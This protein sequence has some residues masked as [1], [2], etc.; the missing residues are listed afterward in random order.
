M[1]KRTDY[2]FWGVAAVLLLLLLQGC[3]ARVKL[4][5]LRRQAPSARL[6][7]SDR[8]PRQS[9]DTVRQ[10]KDT[11][12]IRNIEGRD[13]V[14]MRAIRDDD[15]QM[16]A[17]QVLEAARVTARFRNVAERHGRVDIAFQII[18]PEYLQES[19]WQLRYTPTM[20]IMG[21]SVRLDKVIVTGGAYRRR[22]LRGYQQ[23]RRFLDRIASDSSRMINEG[24]LEVFLRRNIPQ[25]YAFKSDTSYVSD[26]EFNSYF[27]VNEQ[28][29]VWHYTNKVLLRLNEY[30]VHSKSQRFKRYV[31][32]PIVT[33][34]IRLDT[35]IISPSGDYIYNYVHSIQTRPYLK[36]VDIVLDGQI[37]EQ[38]RLLCDIARSDMLNFYISSVSAF[39]DDSERY[40]TKIIERRVESS[41]SYLVEF[42]SGSSEVVESLGDNAA[43]LEEIRHNLRGLM[44][45]EIF[46]VDSITVIASASPEGGSAMNAALSQ[47]R[48]ESMT[49]YFDSFVRRQRDSLRRQRGV[50]IAVDDH[51]RTLSVKEADDEPI[52]FL[53][54]SAGEDWA[55]LGRLVEW[56]NT[57]TRSDKDEYASLVASMANADRRE[58]AMK[59]RGWYKYM[60]ENLYPQLRAVHFN[61][62][63]HRRGL[64]KD[65]V[66][67]TVLDTVYMAGVQAIKDRDYDRAIELLR[68]YGDYNTAVAYCAKDYNYSALSILQECPHT[69]Q[70][71]YMLALLHARLGDSQAAVDCYV[72]SCRQDGKYVHR[73]NLDP[74]ISALIRE[75]SLGEVLD[76]LLSEDETFLAD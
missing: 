60:Y 33:S 36:K 75:Y 61:F 1:K 10:H 52:R 56:D 67:T 14:V 7:L 44:S 22:Q 16:V 28:E 62:H 46:A 69:A 8:M 35:V 37:Y 72:Q 45:N 73:G 57:L 47:R 49:R 17:N 25:I 34:G 13:M 30:R 38:D 6:A 4:A 71:N 54:R 21:D 42:R 5:G 63:L 11:L 24:A 65:T 58:T 59:G 18:V 43:K 39:V 48:S 29:A 64:V 53:A 9:A 15:G 26:E 3:A 20:Y 27:G 55:A 41:N 50:M 76:K 70:V 68:P 66:H 32:A 74:E 2:F 31:K 40:L 19:E 51:G 23:Y 12:L